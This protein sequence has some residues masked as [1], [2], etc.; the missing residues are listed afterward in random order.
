[1]SSTILNFKGVATLLHPVRNPREPTKHSSAASVVAPVTIRVLGIFPPE[2]GDD[3]NV[4]R[5]LGY[6]LS[7]PSREE[8]TPSFLAYLP[9][10]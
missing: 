2:D 9:F 7:H 10:G 3:R 8:I 6:F 4:L 1:M 5:Y